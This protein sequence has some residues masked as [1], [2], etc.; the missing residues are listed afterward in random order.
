ML[1]DGFIVHR[2]RPG[3]DGD[4]SFINPSVADYFVEYFSRGANEKW[5]V[6]E[7]AVFV[8][9]LVEKFGVSNHKPHLY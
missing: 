1:L 5:R 9:Q 6:L 8:E 7:S 3:M 2:R 4:Y